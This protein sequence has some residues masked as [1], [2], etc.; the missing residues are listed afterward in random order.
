VRAIGN[1]LRHQYQGL[2]DP[3]VWKVVTDELPRLELAIR[4]IDAG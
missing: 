2:S 3:I 4:A 1:V